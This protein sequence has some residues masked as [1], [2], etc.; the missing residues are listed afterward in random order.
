MELDETP[1]EFNPAHLHAWQARKQ[2]VTLYGH[3]ALRQGQYGTPMFRSAWR[4]LLRQ[5]RP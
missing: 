4:G 5:T 3:R 1:E 2:N